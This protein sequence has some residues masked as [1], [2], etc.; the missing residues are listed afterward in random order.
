MGIRLT[1]KALR[2]VNSIRDLEEH[3]ASALA[4]HEVDS[5]EIDSVC[6]ALRRLERTWADYIH[7]GRS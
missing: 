7:Y 1:E 6:R 4:E 2:V 5:A 3:H